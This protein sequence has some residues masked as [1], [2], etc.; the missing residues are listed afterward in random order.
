[1]KML[2]VIALNFNFGR[3]KEID[4]KLEN[5]FI[6]ILVHTGRILGVILCHGCGLSI[7]NAIS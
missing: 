4:W 7:E 3:L 2:L 5:N 6:V 1:M